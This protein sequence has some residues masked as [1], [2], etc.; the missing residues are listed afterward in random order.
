[1]LLSGGWGSAVCVDTLPNGTEVEV[2]CEMGHGANYTFEKQYEGMFQRPSNGDLSILLTMKLN[3]AM[4]RQ[5][6]NFVTL[7]SLA[8]TARS[9]RAVPT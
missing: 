3:S 2:S 5:M 7:A 1:M 9:R 8:M 6:V 4:P